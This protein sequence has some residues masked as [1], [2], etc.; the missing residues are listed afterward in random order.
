MAITPSTL[1]IAWDDVPFIG[2]G[3]TG[4]DAN[5]NVAI[6]GVVASVVYSGETV[7]IW[8]CSGDSRTFA[9]IEGKG[10]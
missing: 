1:T 3:F 8:N 5:H 4:Y 6:T 10:Y 2:N 7:T 9:C